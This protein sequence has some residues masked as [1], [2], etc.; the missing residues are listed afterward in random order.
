MILG[1][2]TALWLILNPIEPTFTFMK[3]E[4]L[5]IISVTFPSSSSAVIS[6]TNTGPNALTIL[7]VT[8]DYATIT[9]AYGFFI[10]TNG[11]LAYGVSGTITINRWTWTAGY[12]YTFAIITTSGNKYTYTTTA[13][14]SG[15]LSPDD[16]SPFL[17]VALLMA[18]I[19]AEA[20][21][22]AINFSPLIVASQIAIIEIVVLVE[23]IV[24]NRKHSQHN[25][26]APADPLKPPSILSLSGSILAVLGI[27]MILGLFIALWLVVS[28]LFPPPTFAL[29]FGFWRP[30][31]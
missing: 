9:P 27:V 28:Y 30:V 12:T 24:H 6:V 18:I 23:V 19:L 17:K 3:T 15:P 14:P 7:Y 29:P 16:S 13:T 26:S 2:F 10:G 4:G 25:V 8:I 5:K 11:T 22:G 20:L 31:P 21:M 1:L